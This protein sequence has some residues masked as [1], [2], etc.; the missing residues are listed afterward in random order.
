MTLFGSRKNIGKKSFPREG[1]SGSRETPDKPDTLE[2]LKKAEDKKVEKAARERLDRETDHGWSCGGISPI[3]GPCHINYCGDD[4]SLNVPC[5][6]TLNVPCVSEHCR[7]T[8]CNRCWDA[9]IFDSGAEQKVDSIVDNFATGWFHSKVQCMTYHAGMDPGKH[10]T[11]CN[12]SAADN[13]RYVCLSRP[14]VNPDYRG[15]GR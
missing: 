10:C 3:V 11:S 2:N 13:F 9:R 7:H 15:R 1:H 4:H 12:H 14:S 8:R 6:S 5:A